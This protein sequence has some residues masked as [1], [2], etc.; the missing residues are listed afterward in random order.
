MPTLFP[1][2]SLPRYLIV[3]NTRYGTVFSIKKK[4]KSL[5]CAYPH[6]YYYSPHK[7]K[8][9]CWSRL[10]RVMKAELVS[11][12]IWVHLIVALFY[13][14]TTQENFPHKYRQFCEKFQLHFLPWSLFDNKVVKT[15]K[16]KKTINPHPQWQWA[17]KNM[18]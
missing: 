11:I 10:R 18:R 15:V 5:D 6:L 3:L 13:L 4:T 9:V 12:P 1:F 7:W 17:G 8:L 2:F 16:R 14:V